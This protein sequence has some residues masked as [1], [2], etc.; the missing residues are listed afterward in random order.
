MSE[1]GGRGPLS[2]DEVWHGL[3][4]L[5]ARYD[6]GERRHPRRLAQL[7]GAAHHA[8]EGAV[9]E[10]LDRVGMTKVGELLHEIGWR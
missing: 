2:V 5:G 6:R 9:T 8:I 7:R 3:C 1:F 10:G 4:E